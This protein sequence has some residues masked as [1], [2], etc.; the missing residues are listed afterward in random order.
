[1]SMVVKKLAVISAVLTVAKVR[2]SIPN[3]TLRP[4]G[5]PLGIPGRIAAAANGFSTSNR[6]ADPRSVEDRQKSRWSPPT[7][8]SLGGYERGSGTREYMRLL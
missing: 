4:M 2:S 8:V 6:L 1:M 7:G 5:Y 3:D